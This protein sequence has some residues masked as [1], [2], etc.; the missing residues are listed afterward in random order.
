MSNVL[1]LNGVSHPGAPNALGGGGAGEPEGHLVPT[2]VIAVALP[3]GP[4]HGLQV[5]ELDA[6]VARL[7]G[8]HGGGRGQ[9]GGGA[10]LD[11]NLQDLTK[12][13]KFL[14]HYTRG[15]VT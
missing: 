2:E 9:D 15:H 14:L 13:L 10:L 7:L 3:D 11:V 6:G 8:V 4:A 12:P 5:G 1:F